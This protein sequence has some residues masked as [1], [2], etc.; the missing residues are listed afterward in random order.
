MPNVGAF[1]ACGFLATCFGP[2]GWMPDASLA[3]LVEPMVHYLLPLLIGYTGGR[4]VHGARGGV[5]GAI[6]TMGAAVG[7][8][9]P[10]F[11]AAMVLGP[12]SAWLLRRV[13]RWTEGRVSPGFGM[14]TNNLSLGLLGGGCAVAALWGVGPLVGALGAAVSRSLG[15][16]V[17][18]DLLP[19]TH[20]LI[21]PGKVIFLNNAINHGILSPLATVE[22]Q[23]AGKSLLFMLE[24][25]PGPGFG[26]LL[27]CWLFG[28][29]ETRRFAP[30]AAAIEFLG[31][32]H[33]VYFPQ[34][35]MM[36]RLLLA[37]VAGG[38]S[39]TFVAASL[40]AGL[41]AAPSPGSVLTWVALAPRGGL[42]P[43]LAAVAVA[44]AVS[45]CLAA[46]LL[47]VAPA[48]GA[49]LPSPVADAADEVAGAASVRRDVRKIVFACDAGMGSS[50]LG[51]GLLRNRFRAAG[52]QV[53][54]GTCAIDELPADADLVLT[55]ESLVAL[56]RRK[57]PD[58]EH[59][60]VRNFLDSSVYDQ[61]VARLSRDHE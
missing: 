44:T 52:I 20:L 42:L 21:E 8:T 41:V 58:A 54:I 3:R 40:G 14:L 59:V 11:I 27:A 50:V 46:L 61:I 31:G 48:G 36:P 4:C 22:A 25:N 56:A 7:A 1:I 28:P 60:P 32:I 6:A 9:A 18:H 34:V 5:I 39:G 43:V 16:I 15:G 2:A 26:L 13:D 35:L 38:A 19:L 29:G 47:K 49:A 30:W 37:L 23:T 33:E 55:H 51:A 10:M 57:L 53:P 45:F 17:A 24:S 12:G